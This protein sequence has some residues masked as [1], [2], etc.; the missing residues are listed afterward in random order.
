MEK[1]KSTS[2]GKGAA[3][4]NCK[5]CGLC[6]CCGAQQDRFCNVTKDDV[7]KLPPRY[8]KLVIYPSPFD[9]LAGVLDGKVADAA[10]KTKFQVRVKAGPLKDQFFTTCTALVGS[11]G[12]SV[13]CAVYRC[14]PDVCKTAVVPGDRTCMYLRREYLK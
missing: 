3:R 4:I 14:R 5:S 2:R 10:L 11:V 7:K 6:C 1:K 8:R 9:M 13:H 12:H